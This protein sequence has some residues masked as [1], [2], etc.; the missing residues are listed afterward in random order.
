MPGSRALGSQLCLVYSCVWAVGRQTMTIE[1]SAVLEHTKR[2]G[3]VRYL[4]IEVDS[5]YCV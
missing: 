3:T 2:E 4:G 5:D 1:C